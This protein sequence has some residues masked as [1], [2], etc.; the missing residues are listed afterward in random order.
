MK[1][2]LCAIALLACGS[3]SDLTAAATSPDASPTLSVAGVFCKPGDAMKELAA[4]GEDEFV[5]YV[6]TDGTWLYE[7]SA[8]SIR[9]MSCDGGP[10]TT[11]TSQ[12]TYLGEPWNDG[13]YF[14]QNGELEWMRHD[15]SG[16]NAVLPL[17]SGVPLLIV[18]PVTYEFG[19]PYNVDI[20]EV[21]L[22]DDSSHIV[23]KLVDA[24]PFGDDAIAVTDRYLHV[25]VEQSVNMSTI[26][27]IDHRID[28][29][30]GSLH[31][32]D[33]FTEA[34]LGPFG[35]EMP[36]IAP[37]ASCKGEFCAL[38]ERDDVVILPIP[39]ACAL[40]IDDEWAYYSLPAGVSRV[41][42]RT[43]KLETVIPNATALSMA[44]A[45]GCLYVTTVFDK[46][47]LHIVRIPR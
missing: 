37:N 20:S 25:V 3:R 18:P 28:R 15:G 6:A 4:L 42:L 26:R 23:A 21:S 7:A 2:A 44:E 29:V 14:V 45:N 38:D 47:G 30:D 5:D 8:D 33:L 27:F 24:F 22:Q 34:T 41:G 19:A 11:L 12:G 46:P 35:C 39:H 1:W 31:D 9:M 36:Q 40:M 16:K 10:T 13:V 17:A 32:L 43:G